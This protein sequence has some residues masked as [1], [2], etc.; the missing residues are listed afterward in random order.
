MMRYNAGA[1]QLDHPQ[2][3]KAPEIVMTPVPRTRIVDMVRAAPPADPRVPALQTTAASVRC[4]GLTC[5]GL[6]TMQVKFRDSGTKGSADVYTTPLLQLPLEKKI[7]DHLTWLPI[8][9]NLM[10]CPSRPAMPARAFANAI[11]CAHGISTQAVEQPSRCLPLLKLILEATSR[12][13]VF[14]CLRVCVFALAPLVAVQV[15]DETVL[16]HIPYIH[17][18]VSDSRVLPDLV[19]SHITLPL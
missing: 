7:P 4:V 1:A 13:C 12:V 16:R 10:V 19:P 5:A 17:D 3:D 11:P 18:D 6:P 15:E 2:F 9:R 8:R 14:A